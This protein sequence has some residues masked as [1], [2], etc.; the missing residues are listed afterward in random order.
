MS[1][2][3]TES[4]APILE[5]GLA[6]LEVLA[7]REDG[8]T[9]TELSN[10]LEISTATV[11]RILRVLDRLGHLRRD[12]STKRYFLTR[13]LLLVSQPKTSDSSLVECAIG[14]MR[15]VRRATGETTQ[16]GCVVGGKWVL[17]D[18]LLATHPFK[19]SA[20]LGAHCPVYS[21]APGKAVLAFMPEEDREEIIRQ[22]RFKKFTETTISSRRQLVEECA[23]IRRDGYALDR[24]EGMLGIHCIAAPIVNRHGD[25]IA[26]ITIAAPISRVPE[27]KFTEIG[28]LMADA[29]RQASVR[30][31]A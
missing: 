25:A 6:I 13:K 31:N 5:R 23:Q 22:I 3:L 28:L 7:T 21:C 27:S 8:A 12:E 19:Y 9:I 24:Q 17:L 16:I 14:P 29:A 11:F 30:F 1:V 10:S 20:D 26:A 15:E 2:A 4:K 18:Q